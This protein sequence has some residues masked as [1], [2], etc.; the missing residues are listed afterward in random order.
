VGICELDSCEPAEGPEA[1]S[2][3]HG[4]ELS[5]FTTG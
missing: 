4:K 2:C 3:E 1:G 5:G